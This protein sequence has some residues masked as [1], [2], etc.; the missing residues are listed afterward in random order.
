MLPSFNSSKRTAVVAQLVEQSLPTLEVC[1]LKPVI[2]KLFCLTFVYCS[3]FVFQRLKLPILNNLSQRGALLLFGIS[4][5]WS[6]AK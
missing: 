4:Q 3:T 1:G 2:G 5:D 6:H